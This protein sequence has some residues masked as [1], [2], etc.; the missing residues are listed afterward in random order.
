MDY[1]NSLIL[2]SELVARLERRQWRESLRVPVEVSGFDSRGRFF[3]ERTSTLDVSDSGYFFP[4]FP[5]RGSRKE[6]CRF[7]ARG[8]APQWADAR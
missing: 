1:Q 6:Q 3:T 8:S 5:Q 7:G 4:S 2:E